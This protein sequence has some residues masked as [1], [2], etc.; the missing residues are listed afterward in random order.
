MFIRVKSTP[1]TLKRYRDTPP[2]SGSEKRGLLEKGSFQKSRFSR[3]SR[4]FRDSRESRD[5]RDCGKTKE[6]LTMFWRSRELEIL[7]I[8]EIPPVKIPLLR[9]FCTPPLAE[10]SIFITNLYHDSHLYRDAVAEV[11]GSGVVGAPT[12]YGLIVID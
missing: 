12:I 10:C 11:L 2:I 4:E 9:Y 7:E 1:D 8:L 3:D 5:S 6:N